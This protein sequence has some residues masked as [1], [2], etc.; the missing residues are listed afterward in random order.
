MLF[1]TSLKAQDSSKIEIEHQL[2][3]TFEELDSEELG[4][5]GEQLIQ[6]L[7][8]LATNPI[9]LNVASISDLLQIP[10]F[11][12]NIAKSVIDYRAIKS[13]ES[14]NELKKINGIGE[15]MFQRMSPYVTTSGSKSIFNSRY[16]NPAYWLNGNKVEVISRYQQNIEDQ[17]G[18]LRTDSLG[19]YVG[20]S[21][22]YY[23]RFRIQSNHFSMNLTQEKDPGEVLTGPTSFDYN[24]WHLALTKNGSLQSLVVG[25][26]SLSVG[27]GLVIWT[28]GTF[29]K[30][31][32]VTGTINKN[33]R[34]LRPY[35]SVQE[36]DFFRGIAATYGEKIQF[37]A[38]FSN[39]PRTASIIQGDTTRFPSS[40][41]FHRTES[42][43]D[44]RNNIDQK[45]IGGRI[46]A[47][48]RLGWIGF[49]GYRTEFSSF[50]IKGTSTSDIYDFEGRANSVIGM[51]YRGL[52][53]NSLV[54][55]EVARS[56]NGG[57]GAVTGMKTSLGV[58]TELA[59]LFRDYQKNFQSF[60]GR[61]FGE[62]SG[63][64]NNE[65]GIYLGLKHQFRKKYSLSGYIDQYQF[66]GPRSGTT[67]PTQGYD[68]LG[69]IEG[70]IAQDLNG[71]VL[72]RNEVK[73]DEFITENDQGREE[74]ILGKE[75]RTSIRLQGEYQV[76]KKVRLRSRGE[77]VRYRST[78]ATWESGFLVFQDLRIQLNKKLQLDT[79][80][81]FFDTDSFNTRVYQFESDLLYVLSNVVLSD[82]GD[83]IYT[84]LKYEATSYFQLW[85]KYSLTTIEDAQTLSSGL[86]KIE[87]NKKSFLGIQARILL[88]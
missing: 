67:Q 46:K 11:S 72:I 44:R 83:K 80:V 13:F 71:Y 54:F 14:I 21:V 62:S 43:L 75:K 82:Q 28:G 40:S 73:E 38:F 68:V 25:D 76:T 49:T 18:F 31:R 85:L 20:N 52:I 45:T 88:K 35:G 37:T 30:G 50:V 41:G 17:E 77:F 7:E 8:D 16:R 4:L 29:G 48:T 12:L 2:E 51:D 32:E 53:G 22:K 39:R 3:E 70:N 36:T 56:E 87:G 86:G 60:M 42:E 19:G 64:P 65:S 81:T 6:F 24:S 26:Y 79:R 5:S 47:D 74:R 15:G 61:G 9:N 59:I 78:G 23:Q 84:V 34:G 10:G 69:L 57:F 58:D 63:N 66:E 27:Q 1:S 55:G 33:E